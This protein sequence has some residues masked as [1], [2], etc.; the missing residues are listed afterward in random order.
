LNVLDLV[1]GTPVGEW[2]HLW[3]QIEVAMSAFGVE[4]NVDDGDCG[5]RRLDVC[6]VFEMKSDDGGSEICERNVVEVVG[7]RTVVEDD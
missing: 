7:V 6:H 1:V 4:L 2:T 3:R 5:G